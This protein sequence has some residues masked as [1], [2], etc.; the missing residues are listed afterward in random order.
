MA[1]S[2]VSRSVTRRLSRT[3]FHDG[4]RFDF[5]CRLF[6]CGF[7]LIG[8]FVSRFN[9]DLFAFCGGAGDECSFALFD[10]EL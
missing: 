10:A 7:G 6:A 9:F 3:T 4:F 8:V 2:N 1:L 5:R